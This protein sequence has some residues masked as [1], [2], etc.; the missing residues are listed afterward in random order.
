MQG[1]TPKQRT[2]TSGFNFKKEAAGTAYGFGDKAQLI[3]DDRDLKSDLNDLT[4]EDL[5][6]RLFVAERVMKSLF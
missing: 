1:G 2:M 3:G 5:R 6:E 4:K